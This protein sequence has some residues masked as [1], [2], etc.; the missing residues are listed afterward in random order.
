MQ[1]NAVVG[2]I[3]IGDNTHVVNSKEDIKKLAENL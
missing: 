1:F 2:S 3:R